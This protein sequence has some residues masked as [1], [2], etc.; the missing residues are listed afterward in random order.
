MN[1]EAT[2]IFVKLMN[3]SSKATLMSTSFDELKELF[4]NDPVA[5]ELKVKTILEEYISTLEPERQQRARA[6]QWRIEQELRN[7]NDPVARMNKM[8]EM[9]W[10]GVQKFQKVLN[11]P[12]ILLNQQG[13]PVAKFPEKK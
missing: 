13:E 1:P 6:Y 11:H 3:I 9:F 7:Y 12:K 2:N 4:E 10:T 8:V 5:A